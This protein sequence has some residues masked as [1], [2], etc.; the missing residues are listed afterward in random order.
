MPDHGS[1]ALAEQFSAITVVVRITRSVPFA[2]QLVGRTRSGSAPESNGIAH[3]DAHTH[4]T[5]D[6]LTRGLL[7]QEPAGGVNAVAWSNG[8][9]LAEL[10]GLNELDD[11]A[12]SEVVAISMARSA[13]DSAG[14]V[15]SI[16]TVTGRP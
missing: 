9:L 5:T 13:H 14:S 1:D 11:E 16:A 3:G 15:D 4:E 6:L 2:A 8:K 7:R 10:L 12:I